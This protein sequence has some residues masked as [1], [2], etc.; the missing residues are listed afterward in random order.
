MN[1]ELQGGFHMS[2]APGLVNRARCED[3]EEVRALCRVLLTF[4]DISKCSSNWTVLTFLGK[5]IYNQEQWKE[6]K[7]RR[8]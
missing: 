1:W 2:P 6:G 3:Q 5:K 7:R 4:P 8:K